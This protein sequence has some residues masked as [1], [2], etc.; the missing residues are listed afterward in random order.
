MERAQGPGVCGAGP[1]CSSGL[2][3]DLAGGY[4]GVFGKPGKV[5]INKSLVKMEKYKVRLLLHTS[6]FKTS[7]GA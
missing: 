3:P 4:G 2:F 6:Y 7:G 5:T 1:G